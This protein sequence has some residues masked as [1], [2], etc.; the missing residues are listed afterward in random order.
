MNA[1]EKESDIEGMEA[2]MRNLIL[3]N[4]HRYIVHYI[5]L[6]LCDNIW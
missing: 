5:L 2:K 3:M 4:D 6:N 1:N